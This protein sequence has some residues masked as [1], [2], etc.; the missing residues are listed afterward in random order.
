[1][2]PY[3]QLTHLGKLRRLYE[4]AQL[5]LQQYDIDPVSISLISKSTNLIYRIQ[6]ENRERWIIRLAQP[7]WRTK[8]DLESGAMWMEAIA[9]DCEIPVATIKRSKKG[10]YVATA[11]SQSVPNPWHI[12]V[13]SWLPGRL[14]GSQLNSS[15]LVRMG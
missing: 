11:V 2:K 4:L 6:T 1:M 10:E 12:I 15:N 3:E 14:L 9:R 8:K 13:M 7:G 5:A